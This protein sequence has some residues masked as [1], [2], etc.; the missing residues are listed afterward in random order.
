MNTYKNILY[1]INLNDEN[2]TSIIY[3]LEFARL[4]NS[5]IHIVYVN[6]PQA[7][8][9]HPTD[10]EDAVAL[11][12][13]ETVSE[14]LLENL[15]VVYAVSKGNTA[16]EI[17]RYAQEHQIDLIMVGHKHRGKLY[18]TLFDSDDVNIIDT[19]QLPVLVIPEK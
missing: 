15:D 6:D 17:V 10:R 4:F 2:I 12:V 19:A 7:G 5:R 14:S 9:R 1:A 3:A 11:R 8:Y 16:E 13:R 18:S